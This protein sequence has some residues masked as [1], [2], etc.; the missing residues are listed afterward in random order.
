MLP[1]ISTYNALICVCDADDKA[2]QSSDMFAIKQWPSVASN[3][4]KHD[5]DRQLEKVLGIISAIHR[6]GLVPNVVTFNALISACE[7]ALET[8]QALETLDAMLRSGA[9]PDMIVYNALVKACET[10]GRPE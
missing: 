3:P 7:K 9:V 5:M 2:E 8:V 1:D 6:Q 10:G 4:P